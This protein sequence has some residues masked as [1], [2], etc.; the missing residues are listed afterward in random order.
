MPF[1]DRLANGD[2]KNGYFTTNTN[3]DWVKMDRLRHSPKGAFTCSR[4][5]IHVNE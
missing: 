5:L 1:L 3:N 4:P 2:E